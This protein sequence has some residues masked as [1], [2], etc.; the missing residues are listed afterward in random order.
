MATQII[1]KTNCVAKN[2]NSGFSIIKK[3]C[4][5][6]MTILLNWWILPFVKL[7]TDGLATN[8]L[9]SPVLMV[10]NNPSQV[11]FLLVAPSL[12]PINLK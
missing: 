12:F 3:K 2:I 9:L 8:R 7:H 5:K 11:L 10:V 4:P 6:V 1:K